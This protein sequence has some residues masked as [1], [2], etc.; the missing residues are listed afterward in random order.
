M[1]AAIARTSC[2][3]NEPG[4]EYQLCFW[5]EA[6]TGTPEQ[7]RRIGIGLDIHFPER[8]DGRWKRKCIDPRGLEV[9]LE[10]SY[11]GNNLFSA[12]IYSKGYE[13]FDDGVTVNPYAFGVTRSEDTYGDIFT[14]TAEAL[15]AA[16]IVPAGCFPGW[17]GMRKTAVSIR[18]DG[19][20]GKT[21]ADGEGNKVIEIKSKGL[22][23]TY[24]CCVRLSNEVMEQRR[25]REKFRRDEWIRRMDA[26]PKPTPLID[27][28]GARS[29]PKVKLVPEYRVDGNVIHLA[30]RSTWRAE[31][32]P[33]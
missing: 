1:S 2:I 20:I 21:R 17:P 22:R 14:G 4:F 16:G 10:G 19:T 24:S 27:L 32:C 8:A 18:P 9:K 29:T 15:V 3:L 11:L 5:G 13:A 31:S 26:L 23:Q 6:I 12:S 30:P 28:P 33:A 7:L 25:E